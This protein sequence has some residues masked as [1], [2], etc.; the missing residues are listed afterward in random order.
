MIKFIGFKFKL[1]EGHLTMVK[2]PEK[3][4][5]KGQSGNCL[6]DQSRVLLKNLCRSQKIVLEPAHRAVT[7]EPLGDTFFS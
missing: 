6:V 5:K 2:K 7:L 4:L 3:L 1:F